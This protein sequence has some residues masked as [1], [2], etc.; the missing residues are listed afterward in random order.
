MRKRNYLIGFFCWIGVS[1]I[2]QSVQFNEM[3]ALNTA[4]LT[5]EAGSYSDWIEL[6]NTSSAPISLEGWTLTDD[7]ANPQKW[8]FPAVTIAPG[9]YLVV[10]ASEKDIKVGPFLHTN[11]KLNE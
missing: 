9:S 10:F 11:F 8:T 4:G 1:A 2:G 3:V 6:V 5:D 7:R